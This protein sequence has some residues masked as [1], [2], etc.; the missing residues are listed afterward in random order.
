MFELLALL[1][2]MKSRQLITVCQSYHTFLP[3]HAK[4]E[5]RTQLGFDQNFG[6]AIDLSQTHPE[7]HGHL[8]QLEG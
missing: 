5:I 7:L 3:L 6:A 8:V 4:P 1:P 2:V